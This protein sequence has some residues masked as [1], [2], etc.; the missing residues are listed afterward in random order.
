MDRKNKARINWISQI[1]GISCCCLTKLSLGWV[2]PWLIWI[3]FIMKHSQVEDMDGMSGW[4]KSCCNEQTYSV[5]IYVFVYI[6]MVYIYYIYYIKYIL[7]IFYI[8]YIL[9]IYYIYYIIY[10]LYIHYIYIYFILYI[11]YIIYYI[12]WDKSSAFAALCKT[13]GRCEQCVLVHFH[14]HSFSLA[15]R[16]AWSDCFK[17]SPRLG[18]GLGWN[19]FHAYWKNSSPCSYPLVN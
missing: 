7:Y 11:L 15:T 9:Y 12:Y 3:N 1:S 6:Y 18:L 19:I 2:L 4:R 16:A 14:Y 5:Y 10:I 13:S 8:L 17:E